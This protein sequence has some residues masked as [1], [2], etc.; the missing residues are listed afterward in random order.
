MAGWHAPVKAG[1]R[2]NNLTG[3]NFFTNEVIV[4]RRLG[5]AP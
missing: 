3:V 5:S 1:L 4:K 2:G